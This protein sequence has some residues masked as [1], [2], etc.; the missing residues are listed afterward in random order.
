LGLV[1]ASCASA[2]DPMASIDFRAM[3][4]EEALS[5]LR[6]ASQ[7][8][9]NANGIP[10]H[11]NPHSW[12]DKD[13]AGCNG[14]DGRLNVN[15][16]EQACTTYLSGNYMNDPRALAFDMQSLFRGCGV[17]AT[18]GQSDESYDGSSCGLLGRLFYQIGN[19]AAARAIWEQAPGC[20]A[21]V[22]PG[23]VQNGCVRYIVKSLLNNMDLPTGLELDAWRHGAVAAYKDDLPVLLQMARKACST[24]W[25]VPG[26][27]LI[28]AP[29]RSAC[30]YVQSGGGRVNMAAVT[31]GEAELRQDRRDDAAREREFRAEESRIADAKTDAVMGALQSVQ[32][33]SNPN[34]TLSVVS[35]SASVRQTF[36]PSPAPQPQV[37]STAPQNPAPPPA[38]ASVGQPASAAASYITP[39]SGSCIREFWD[40]KQYNWLSFQNSCAQTIYLTFIFHHNVGWAMT[41]SMT[42]S[43][44]AQANTG[45]S[46]SDIDQAGGYELYVCPANSVPVDMAGNTLSAN[47]SEYRCKPQ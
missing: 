40:P 47:V 23:T 8:Y 19:T 31:Q 34:A 9:V 12:L 15:A 2:P 14:D 30:E 22:G 45:R 27:S 10:D 46:S 11:G 29:D 17:W 18:S 24:A 41:G 25:F 16:K 20:V 39:L 43:P 38:T 6:R 33:A 42:L 13:V 26:G 5:M 28:M 3:T 32:A 7:I 35:Q 37:Q 1:L 4:P 21:F 36:A 44:G